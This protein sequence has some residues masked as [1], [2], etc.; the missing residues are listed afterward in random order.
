ML[1]YGFI[2]AGNIIQAMHRGAELNP[3]YNPAE[4]GIYDINAATRAAYAKKGY[5]IYDKMSDL[6]DN[7]DVLVLGVTPK[8]AGLVIDELAASYRPG[9]LLLT[10]VTGVEQDWYKEHLGKDSKV[11]I[12]MP[13]MSSQVGE[14]AFAVSRCANCEDED[15]EK[16]TEILNACGLVEEIPDGMMAEILP[17]NGSAPGFFY[18][19]A[20]LMVEEAEKLGLD[21][22]TAVRLFAQ[23][24]KGS[25]EMILNADT[26]LKALETAL[27]L[28]GGA[29]VTALEKIES[30]GFDD[31][32]RE[33]V[34]ISVERCKELGQQ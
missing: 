16:A 25:G 14:G 17:F 29:T 24:M 2:A 4:I 28:P 22:D 21:P 5:V 6:V 9:Q 19:I 31:L 11:I 30:M 33:F 20:N 23:T 34:K 3:D 10:V 32:Y 13:N 7:S 26:D 27:R 15:V 12:C 18:H 1:R 8:V